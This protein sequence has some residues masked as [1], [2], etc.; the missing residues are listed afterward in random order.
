M[1]KGSKDLEH[2]DIGH[3]LAKEDESSHINLF[4]K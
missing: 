1:S 3:D 4:G 2:F